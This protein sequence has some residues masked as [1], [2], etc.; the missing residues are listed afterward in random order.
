[1]V[2]MFFHAVDEEANGFCPIFYVLQGQRVFVECIFAE[3]CQNITC[4]R[5]YYQVS[6]SLLKMFS[7]KGSFDKINYIFPF[8]K[9][10]SK[11]YVV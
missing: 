7:G 3:K 8:Q 10:F 5:L 9:F 6:N 1:M 2:K 11:K 4:K